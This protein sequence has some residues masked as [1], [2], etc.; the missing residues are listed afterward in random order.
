[1]VQLTKPLQLITIEELNNYF[2]DNIVIM[3]SD[4]KQLIFKNSFKQK[5]LL[6]F[7]IM[8]SSQFEQLLLPET[9]INYKYNIYY[10]TQNYSLTTKIFNNLKYRYFNPETEI[11]NDNINHLDYFIK[12]LPAYSQSSIHNYL[13]TKKIYALDNK[14]DYLNLPIIYL[15]LD[16]SKTNNQLIVQEFLDIEEEISFTLTKIS[17][18]LTTNVTLNKI[19]VYLPQ[20]YNHY[21]RLLANYYQI[22]TALD[23]TYKIIAQGE[24]RNFIKQIQ[25]LGLEKTITNLDKIIK[26]QQIKSAILELLNTY[27]KVLTDKDFETF[28]IKELNNVKIE[29]IIYT[30]TLTINKLEN[31]DFSEG[32]YNFILGY[33]NLDF[34]NYNK[35]KDFLDDEIKKLFNMETT[36]S[37]NNNLE[38]NVK[39]I[40]NYLVNQKYN[41]S[42]SKNIGKKKY[43][44]N[45]LINLNNVE[46]IKENIIKNNQRYSTS[47]DTYLYKKELNKKL[48][49]NVKNKSFSYLEQNLTTKQKQNLKLKD[50]NL[51]NWD[52]TEFKQQKSISATL[53]EKYYKDNQKFFIEDILNLKEYNTDVLVM[54]IGTY[55]HQ[56]LDDIINEKLEH[57]QLTDLTITNLIFNYSQAYLE[58]NKKLFNFITPSKKEYLLFKINKYLKTLIKIILEQLASEQFKIYKTEVKIKYIYKDYNFVGKIDKILKDNNHNFMIIDYKSGKAELDFTNEL[59]KEGI[60]LQ[61]LIYFILLKQEEEQVKFAGTYRYKIVPK[62]TQE[63]IRNYLKRYGYTNPKADITAKINLENYKNL[64]LKKDGAFDA[65]SKT[66][67]DTEFEEKVTLVQDIINSFI[68]DLETNNFIKNNN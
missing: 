1:M 14:L 4:L 12:D 33:N 37:Q 46:I 36:I 45:R 15:N 27:H 43:S 64:K 58:E 38:K 50:T 32:N 51:T 7:K 16:I 67:D 42:Y 5:K 23:A 63:P 68:N 6:S 26:N 40:L 11:K 20:N 19:K 44:I 25:E 49:F 30:N 31:F 61:N 48:K 56:I 59:L 21:F 66:L 10:K 8:T 52:L 9:L 2:E 62:I 24:T 35:D 22:P 34:I 41:L 13:Q 55:M 54:H 65:Y 29:N 39:N 60:N 53:I 28:F 18:L 17:A 57:Y 3:K 47:F